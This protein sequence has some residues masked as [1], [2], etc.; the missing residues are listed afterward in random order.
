[1]RSL[2]V[3]LLATLVAGCAL[4][5]DSHAVKLSTEVIPGQVSLQEPE[6]LRVEVRATNV[7]NATETITAD[8]TATEGLS[9]TKP[10][11]TQFTLKPEESRI[12]TFTV[13]V[14]KDIA[15]GDYI[16]DI[17]VRTGNGDVVTGKAKVKVAEKKGLVPYI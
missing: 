16:I 6:T 9:V 5:S 15:P 10:N 11:R 8:A 4:W 13:T 14:A 17:V 12:I 1:M 3:L 2:T 7:G